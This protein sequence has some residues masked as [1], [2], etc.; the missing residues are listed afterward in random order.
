VLDGRH[1]RAARGIAQ[2]G[3]KLGRR[4]V[5]RVRTYLALG[6]TV[7][8]EAHEHDAGAGIGRMERNGDRLTGM[9]PDA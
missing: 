7:G 3:C 1:A 5:M 6:P 4:N 2:D 9:N 8:V